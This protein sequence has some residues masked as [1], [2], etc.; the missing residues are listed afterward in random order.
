MSKRTERVETIFARVLQNSKY[1]KCYAKTRAVYVIPTG[2]H[3]RSSDKNE[4]ALRGHATRS[5][6]IQIR[7]FIDQ[8]GCSLT[9]QVLSH[10][11]L[12]YFLT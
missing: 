3:F 6:G 2:I 5:V 12:R 7:E 9:N 11:T 4:I 10:F 8:Q 1:I